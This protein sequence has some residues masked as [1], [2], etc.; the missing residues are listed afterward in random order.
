MVYGLY[1][2][3][4]LLQVMTIRPLVIALLMEC[5]TCQWVSQWTISL[6]ASLSSQLECGFQRK[7]EFTS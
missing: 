7:G 1:L 3:L 4:A 5:E 2:E 6:S